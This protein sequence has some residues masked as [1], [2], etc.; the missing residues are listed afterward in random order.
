MERNS[1][2]HIK[3]TGNIHH[4]LTLVKKADDLKFLLSRELYELSDISYRQG[5]RKGDFDIRDSVKELSGE[6]TKYLGY[7]R[8]LENAKQGQIGAYED[9]LIFFQ[10]SYLDYCSVDDRLEKLKESIELQDALDMKHNEDNINPSLVRRGN[11]FIE[12]LKKKVAF[13]E[14]KF[15]SAVRNKLMDFLALVNELFFYETMKILLDNPVAERNSAVEKKALFTKNC[16]TYLWVKFKIENRPQKPDSVLKTL[17][18]VMRNSGFDHIIPQVLDTG[19]SEYKAL[20]SSVA[21]TVSQNTLSVDIAG[22][23]EEEIIVPAVPV[24]DFHRM[25]QKDVRSL[26]DYMEKLTLQLS[27]YSKDLVIEKVAAEKRINYTVYDIIGSYDVPL[28]TV[29]FY[30]VDSLFFVYTWVLSELNRTSASLKVLTSFLDTVPLCNAFMDLVA[31]AQRKAVLRKTVFA[32][33][34]IIQIPGE[35]AFEL[36]TMLRMVIQAVEQS[37]IETVIS[38]EFLGTKTSAALLKKTIIVRDSFIDSKM[39]INEHL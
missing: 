2:R 33:N 22:V 39:R 16:H 36:K 4:Y 27:P 5:S 29:V 38:L 13:L 31:D 30:L 18:T 25:S 8:L 23:P 37:F 14:R 24:D 34:T 19:V 32:A 7:I 20:L 28:K 12:D 35:T 15:N 1:R 9:I 21:E 10:N 11:I 26:V 3:D 17:E 6:L